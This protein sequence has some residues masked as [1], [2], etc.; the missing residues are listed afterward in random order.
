M[1][2]TKQQNEATMNTNMAKELYAE[3]DRIL[4][5]ISFCLAHRKGKEKTGANLLRSACVENSGT[6]PEAQV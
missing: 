4:P 6:G 5:S 1:P 2:S 3:I